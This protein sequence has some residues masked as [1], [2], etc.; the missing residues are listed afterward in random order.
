MAGI[1]LLGIHI[2]SN[3]LCKLKI[4]SALADIAH[5]FI[6]KLL[7]PLDLISYYFQR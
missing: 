6:Y 3:N 4:Q 1:S 5:H 2:S 7:N